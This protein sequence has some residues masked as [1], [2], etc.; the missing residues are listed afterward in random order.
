MKTTRL[1]RILALVFLLCAGGLWYWVRTGAGLPQVEPRTAA[2]EVFSAER[3]WDVLR[4]V[5]PEPV[6]HAMGSAAGAAVRERLGQELRGL[7]VEVEVQDTWVTSADPRGGR[8]SLARVR[9]LIGHLPAAEPGPEVLLLAHYDSVAAGPGENDDLAGCV[10]WIEALRAWL[11]ADS[12]PP[13]GIWILFS[14]GEELGLF[15]ARAFAEQHRAMESIGLVINLEARGSSGASRLFET[16]PGNRRWVDLYA[17]HASRP[18]ASSLSVE[19]YRRM[20][21]GSDLSV[22]LERGLAGCNF[23]YIGEW[24]AYHSPADRVLPDALGSL[25]HHGENAMA[26]LRGLAQQPELLARPG[27]PEEPDLVHMDVLGRFLLRYTP[28]TGFPDGRVGVGLGPGRQRPR[29]SAR[30]AGPAR[31][32]DHTCAR[33]RVGLAAVARMDRA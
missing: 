13:V 9:N 10:A 3:A 6:P 12:R 26:M 18:S 22:F 25:Q 1:E 8:Q 5:L 15:G 19:V 2:P 27:E 11:A 16:G 32:L 4:R 30:C 24:S 23:A 7:G 31:C 33:L 20:P 14:E 21:N 29:V 17:R 28:R